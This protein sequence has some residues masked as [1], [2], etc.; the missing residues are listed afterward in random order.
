MRKQL[1][2]QLRERGITDERVLDAIAT[3]PR[4]Y[5]LEPAFEDWAYEDKPFPIGCEQTISQPFTVAIQTSLL[6][7]EARHKVLE[8]GTGSGYQAAILALLGA[9]VFTLER[10]QKLYQKARALLRELK[11]GNVRC[12]HRDGYK[13][14]AEFAPF[15]RILVTAGATEVPETLRR[16]MAI[17]GKLVI[18]VG[19]DTQRMLRLTRKAEE[20]WQEEDF[21]NFRFVP[22][23]KGLSDN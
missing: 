14:L 21:G 6:E 3:L 7:V 12:F 10:H 1:V 9:R 4:H 19:E 13:G 23:V 11:L 5:F 17:G 18:P 8:V 16:Q 2:E 22:F 15:D 20:E